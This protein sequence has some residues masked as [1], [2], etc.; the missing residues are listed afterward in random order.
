MPNTARIPKIDLLTGNRM[1]N[2]TPEIW[3]EI[4]SDVWV[5]PVGDGL[6]DKFIVHEPTVTDT[7]WY[8]QEQWIHMLAPSFWLLLPDNEWKHRPVLSAFVEFKEPVFDNRLVLRGFI[9]DSKSMHLVVGSSA[10][11]P[12]ASTSSNKPVYK[13]LAVPSSSNPSKVYE[14]R[15]YVDGTTS[16]N[17]PG[18]T[19]NSKRSC[20]HVNSTTIQDI[21]ASLNVP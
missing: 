3:W 7:V 6:K 9:I 19:R 5:Y 2:F 14:T 16:C 18:W 15:V 21:I 10:L 1:G 17:C 12:I 13:T 4:P 20:R 8:I 11:R